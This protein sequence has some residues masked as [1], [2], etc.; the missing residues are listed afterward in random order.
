LTVEASGGGPGD[1]LVEWGKVILLETQGRVT[2]RPVRARLGFVEEPDGSLLVAAGD[3]DAAWAANLDA[4]P[5]CRVTLGDRS[6]PAVAEP[7]EGPA[8]A[9][10]IR[11][12]ILRYG[13]P[14]ERL[15]N[16]PAY[17]LTPA[18]GADPG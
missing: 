4:D 11:E 7:I 16:G 13:T 2:G 10:A 6:W 3:A 18:S 1:Q 8:R 12:L 17:R 14:S 15:G 9:R 5:S